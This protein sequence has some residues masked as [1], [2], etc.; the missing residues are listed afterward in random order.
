MLR[1]EENEP[2]TSDSDV[3]EVPHNSSRLI[4]LVMGQVLDVS[5]ERIILLCDEQLDEGLQG[6]QRA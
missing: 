3:I 2:C 5:R 6:I 1:S 4:V